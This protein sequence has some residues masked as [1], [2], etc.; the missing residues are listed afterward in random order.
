[1]KTNQT[2]SGSS[3]GNQ[4]RKLSLS[5]PPTP[6]L[7]SPLSLSSSTSMPLAWPQRQHLL[8]PSSPRS[9][10]HSEQSESAALFYGLLTSNMSYSRNDNDRNMPGKMGL[11]SKNTLCSLCCRSIFFFFC[12]CVFVIGTSRVP[13]HKVID[14][15]SCVR[16]YQWLDEAGWV[17]GGNKRLAGQ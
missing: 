2:E 11:S 7:D 8:S 4:V 13:A 5:S 9:T 6:P 1:M 12:A 17:Q 15:R 3:R 14:G 10:S 16:V